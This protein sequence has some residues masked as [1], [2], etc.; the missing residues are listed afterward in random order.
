MANALAPEVFM[1]KSVGAKSKVDDDRSMR[2]GQ[3]GVKSSLM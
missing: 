3:Y 2:A 1:L